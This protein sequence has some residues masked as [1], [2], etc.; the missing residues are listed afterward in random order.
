MSLIL[1]MNCNEIINTLVEHK[2]DPKAIELVKKNLEQIKNYDQIHKLVQEEI[3]LRNPF[4]K[5][6]PGTNYT[7]KLK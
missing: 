1:D 6:E 7:V 3:N 5:F 4:I 2:T